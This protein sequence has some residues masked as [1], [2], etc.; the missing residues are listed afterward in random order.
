MLIIRICKHCR[1]LPRSGVTR[2]EW[3][4][5]ERRITPSA[6]DRATRRVHGPATDPVTG[7]VVQAHAGSEIQ[8]F[9]EELS[10]ESASGER[11]RVTA[12]ASR[13]LRLS[14]GWSTCPR[15]SVSVRGGTHQ[16]D[17]NVEIIANVND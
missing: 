3:E 16:T 12:P 13:W 1:N 15:A 2:A 5:R 4:D 10:P 9:S 6:V 17:E 7:L 11:L 14:N 8:G